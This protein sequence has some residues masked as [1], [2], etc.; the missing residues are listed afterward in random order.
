MG[1]KNIVIGVIIAIFIGLAS[2]TTLL[3]LRTPSTN[4][5]PTNEL[6]DAFMEG[7]NALILDKQGKPS[8]KI[9]APKLTHFPQDDSTLLT[10]PHL[11]LYRKSPEPWYITS[12][13]AKAYRGLEYVDFW[14]EVEI[15]HAAYEDS[16]ATHI[17]TTTLRV[18]PEEKV[19]DTNDLITMTQPNIVVKA[20]GMHA[21]LNTGDIKL[22]SK[23]R[24]EYVPDK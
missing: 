24:G 18:R 16:P 11:T 8:M 1:Y 19:A 7:V 13:Y 12:H 6:P 22:L 3:S 23:A 10:T 5:I 21:D 20:E 4:T 9:T 15:H 17:K 2:W 14:E